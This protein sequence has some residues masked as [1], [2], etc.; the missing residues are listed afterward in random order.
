[1]LRHFICKHSFFV[2]YRIQIIQ[3]FEYIRCER[4]LIPLFLTSHADR[5]ITRNPFDDKKKAMTSFCDSQI[6]LTV[7]LYQCSTNELFWYITFVYFG[8]MSW[9]WYLNSQWLSALSL[10]V[11][12]AHYRI[13]NT[14]Q[15]QCSFTKSF[16]MQHTL[17]DMVSHSG[18]SAFNSFFLNVALSVPHAPLF[19]QSFAIL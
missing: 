12:N 19:L 14:L 16:L 13:Y 4:H 6:R 10:S 9:R 8:S 5:K 18:Y 17:K 11:N 2:E 15:V 7:R 3:F 1:M